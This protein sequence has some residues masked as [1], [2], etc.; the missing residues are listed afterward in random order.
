MLSP[1][2]QLCSATGLSKGSSL[3]PISAAEVKEVHLLLK[4]QQFFEFVQCPFCDN[5]GRYDRM[6]VPASAGLHA[7]EYLVNLIPHASHAMEGK[8]ER[9]QGP[10]WDGCALRVS[11][12]HN[13]NNN[14]SP[15]G[16]L[17]QKGSH[18]LS[19]YGS[20]SSTA[21]RR[22]LSYVER[23]VLEIVE[24]ERMYV[25]D[26]RS[27]VESYLG[28]IIDVRE[29]L[30]QPD[31]VSALF[32]NIEDIYE[33]SSELLHDLESCD[34]NPVAVAR[35][36]VDRSQDFDIYTQYCNNYP[37]SVAALTECMQNKQQV[38][39][40]R[41]CQEQ[42]QHALPLGAYL[43]KP[44]QRI[45]AYSLCPQ[46]IA[47]HFDLAESGYEVVE[48]A[49]DT[50]TCVAWYINDMKRK[51]EHAVRLQE[52]Q[53]L[54]L[55]WKGPDLTTYGE[56]VLEGTFRV[57]RVR[58]ERTF[59]LFDKTL[60]IT[61][62]RGDHFIYK[63]H[64]PCSSL[65][66]IESTRDS[67]C[68]SVTHYKHSKQQYSLQ[69]RS[70]EEKRVWTHH[71]KRLIL[72]NH[73]A[74]IPQKAKEAI[75]EMDSYYPPRYR[76][77]PEGLK[78]TRS[79]Q[80]MDEVPVHMR[81]LAGRRQ[82]EPF[83]Y[84]SR[85]EKLPQ[86]NGPQGCMVSGCTGRRKSE[87]SKQILKQLGAEGAPA[88]IHREQG[89]PGARR[90]Q[91]WQPFLEGLKHTDSD[92]DF[93]DTGEPLQPPSSVQQQAEPEGDAEE[94]EEEASGKEE[95]QAVGKNS[96]EELPGSDSS[97]MEVGPEEEE[98]PVGEEQ[99]KGHCMPA[100]PK[101]C[102]RTA[103]QSPRSCEKHHS[104]EKVLD[105]P[106]A[107]TD[108]EH[109]EAQEVSLIQEE[110]LA[111]T[112]SDL[113]SAHTPE[114]VLPAQHKEG[115]RD[116][117]PDNSDPATSENAEELKTLSSEEEDDNEDTA[118]HPPRSILPPSVLDQASIIAERFVSSFS[119]RS[120]LAL[121]EGRAST[122][123]P[124]PR[125]ALRSSSMLSL[126]GS[127]KGQRCGSSSDTQSCFL[128]LEMATEGQ[129][130]HSA[131]RSR[132]ASP[133]FQEPERASCRRKESMLSKQDRLLLDKIKSYYDQAEHQDASFSIKRRESLSY[134]PKGLVKNS[135]FR[136]DS[137]PWAAASQDTTN[138]AHGRLGSS[139]AD[140]TSSRTAAWVLSGLP[141]APLGQPEAGGPA[142][143]TDEE[144]RPPSEMIKVW[145][146]MDKQKGKS[147][148]EQLAV[149]RAGTA[150][151]PTS[152]GTEQ[153]MSRSQENGLATREPLLILEDD[154]L[155]AITEESTVPSPES[156]SPTERAMPPR[157]VCHL[158]RL[159]QEL[160][161]SDL[162]QPPLLHPRILQ[163]S[164]A[165]EV[166]LCE[167][168]KTRVYQLAR[169]YS[170][171]IK[172]HKPVLQRHLTELEEDT[173]S[174]VPI[175]LHHTQPEA[176]EEETGSQGK[177]KPALSLTYEQEVIPEQSPLTPRSTSSSPRR[178][179]ST[180]S[181]P[182][183]PTSLASHSPLSPI[184]AEKFSWPD[185]REL[186]SKY[187]LGKSSEAGF[188]PCRPPPVNR[189]RS[190]PE[191]M[192]E[193]PTGALSG[194]A[195]RSGRATEKSWLAAERSRS[196]EQGLEPST[197]SRQHQRQH[198]DGV[199]YVA[200]ETCLDNQQR[201]IVLEKVPP[202]AESYVQ[203]RS[204]TTREKL[205]LKAVAERCKVYQDLDGCPQQEWEDEEG[206]P[207]RPMVW[208]KPDVGH[209]G[210]VRNLREKFQTLN[211]TC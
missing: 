172:R 130:L 157:L 50:M 194:K 129:Q 171:R 15:R 174:S 66:L 90:L 210:L 133:S 134:I 136:I 46:E 84:C 53:S 204:P 112:C 30:L 28:K 181:Y 149:G 135:V 178:P 107:A 183:S 167:R 120:S 163:L 60:L 81:H 93:L 2:K 154:D 101:G 123:I 13:S 77:S 141:A 97:E 187:S 140:G 75:L 132:T 51:H 189:S 6:P 110:C 41:E 8:E 147:W 139:M 34:N 190:A 200:A 65:M 27:I 155:S 18:S 71:I 191:K 49:I 195:G 57:Q 54:L 62:K 207:Q 40:F 89:V 23:V 169:Q 119:R 17:G 72:E 44:V 105:D 162:G 176:E 1:L 146:G 56:L 88:D 131:A 16:W 152:D 38:R 153:P 211:S 43:L 186:R 148:K 29:E 64:I 201:V 202:D 127:E 122:G 113:E 52:I 48:E 4:R 179:S 188:G 209:Q 102:K 192:A 170:L 199:L 79:N 35:C 47:K 100:G 116:Q 203:I 193:G 92:G 73:H 145:E 103:S 5:I 114:L 20:K 80:P 61:K 164:P 150:T 168:T 83:H 39:F 108:M 33:L 45:L 94:T 206:Q 138:A 36:F 118:L 74:I 177:Q 124:T 70:V 109:E 166:E 69:A 117:H 78:K 10:T 121:D 198:S 180:S 98:G 95:E 85:A 137:L 184:L 58:N 12:L 68:F 125:L 96:L 87:P 144:F 26:L 182:V 7:L 55:N 126:E 25:Q 31:Q 156:K 175:L 14:A 19:P 63:S 160:G 37:N 24:S 196:A 128:P 76:C 11:H 42:M 143:I 106:E 115:E 173:R 197:G 158:K 86:Y 205:S 21:G 82:S 161:T 142:P 22:E 104:M 59:F 165:G 99:G 3:L 32:G 111:Q 151:G 91:G 159:A 67:L 9:L 185:V 208:D